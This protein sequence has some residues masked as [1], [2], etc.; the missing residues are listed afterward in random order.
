MSDLVMEAM[1]AMVRERTAN[2]DADLTATGLVKVYG[3]RTVVNGMNV[4]CSCGEIIGILG[5]NGAGKTTTF[6][7][8]VG[9]RNGPVP[10]RGHHATSRLRPCAQGSRLSRTGGE[11]LPQAFGVGQRDGDSR[12]VAAFA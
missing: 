6:Y 8:I 3:D 7:M 12:D 4:K 1:G 5:P 10:R 11:R 9:G 2:E